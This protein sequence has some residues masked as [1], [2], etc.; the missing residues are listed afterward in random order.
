MMTLLTMSTGQATRSSS[1]RNDHSCH[2][3]GGSWNARVADRTRLGILLRYSLLVKRKPVPG[4]LHWL[5]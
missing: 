3:F 5:R 2:F 1:F 4:T